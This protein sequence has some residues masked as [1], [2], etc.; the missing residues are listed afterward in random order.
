MNPKTS[1]LIVLPSGLVAKI[2][3]A[4]NGFA[5]KREVAARFEHV[6][7]T[8]DMLRD[9]V[10]GHRFEERDGITVCRYTAE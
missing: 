4:A 1:P 9:M 6:G 10:D 3:S 8:Y 5:T 2:R 7:L